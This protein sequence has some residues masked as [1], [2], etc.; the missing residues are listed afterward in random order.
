MFKTTI[1]AHKTP[2]FS[3]LTWFLALSLITGPVMAQVTSSDFLPAARAVL[4]AS[5]D[6]QPLLLKG[7][8]LYPDDPLRFDFIVGA[9]PAGSSA[10]RSPEELRRLI[11]YFLAALAIPEENFW[12]NLAPDEPDRIVPGPLAKTA[13]GLDLLGED[14]VL[15]QLAASLTYPETEAGKRYWESLQ[16]ASGA[17]DAAIARNRNQ[18]LPIASSARLGLPRDGAGGVSAFPKVWIVPGEAV[19]YQDA[20]KVFI[21]EAKLK[22]MMEKDYVEQQ[23]SNLRGLNIEFTSNPGG[24]ESTQAAFRQH[25]LP[26][27]EK[28]VNTG[29]RFARLRQ[30]YHAFLLAA[31]FKLRAGRDIVSVSYRDR[32]KLKGVAAANPEF[33][34]QVYHRYLDSFRHGVY[35]Y[36]RKTPML[37]KTARRRYF[38]G[39][40]DAAQGEYRPSR[41][42]LRSY[43]VWHSGKVSQV[44]E[45]MPAQRVKAR[46]MPLLRRSR[47]ARKIVATN[48]AGFNLVHYFIVSGK[49]FG[50]RQVSNAYA[51]ADLV[52][53]TLEEEGHEKIPGNRI[54]YKGVVLTAVQRASKV[55]WVFH[56]MYW[57]LAIKV[58][59][60]N[61][62]AVVFD[63]RVHLVISALGLKGV[64]RNPGAKAETINAAIMRERRKRKGDTPVKAGERVLC[65]GIEF[66]AVKKGQKHIVWTIRRNA[67]AVGLLEIGFFPPRDKFRFKPKLQIAASQTGLEGVYE[68][69]NAC[70]AKI[71]RVLGDPNKQML[72]KT[73]SY[74]KVEFT[75]VRRASMQVWS[76]YRYRAT[77]AQVATAFGFA[78]IK[79]IVEADHD[80]QIVFSKRQ[81][82]GVYADPVGSAR[83]VNLGLGVPRGRLGETILSPGRTPFTAVKEG[84]Q[85]VWSCDAGYYSEVAEEFSLRPSRGV[86]ARLVDA[87]MDAPPVR[88]RVA[89]R[90]R[91][92]SRLLAVPGDD[93]G[94]VDF[95]DTAT[96][97]ARAG[98]VPVHAVSPSSQELPE[99]EG[100]GFIITAPQR[101]LHH[102]SAVVQ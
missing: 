85:T 87:D 55:T 41:V 77:I 6:Y 68:D 29:A 61:V 62:P 40:F 4:A 83:A 26:L 11:K 51:N 75:V 38:C 102:D 13:L 69:P 73:R 27:I 16:G 91:A 5:R 18:Q 74:G 48:T 88:N 3:A 34:G 23:I 100:F 89:A 39:G 71:N 63:K 101:P 82:Q 80:R 43:R 9:G 36:V 44:L 15:K 25:I 20:D 72:G 30:I 10:Y 7:L 37:H 66:T 32:Q 78:L 33:K 31:W 21:A 50:A 90:S 46:L 35:D 79:K 24:W 96:V 81:L 94:G 42:V 86:G 49:G 92:R 60:L 14:Y 99:L 1:F 57:P 47:T 93:V 84:T 67:T 95:D 97:L 17:R 59:K 8:Q 45:A 70:A 53:L 12:V 19:I 65:R 98:V 58:F 22:V 76:F 64:C 54:N 28:E 2:A 56:E 52:N